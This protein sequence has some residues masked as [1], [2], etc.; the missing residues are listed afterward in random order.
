MVCC[1][2]DDAQEFWVVS[3]L[4]CWVG[5]GMVMVLVVPSNVS[6]LIH[7]DSV[8]PVPMVL[9]LVAIGMVLVALAIESSW[10]R[11]GLAFLASTAATIDTAAS[12]LVTVG[13]VL[14]ALANESSWIRR[15]LAFWVSMVVAIDC[16]VVDDRRRGCCCCSH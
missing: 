15:G 14:A 8:L 9:F 12:L 16:V 10:I 5:V 13:M 11:R 6:L 4:C 3:S 1:F 7:S 2:V